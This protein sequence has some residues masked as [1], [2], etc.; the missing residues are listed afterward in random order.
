MGIRTGKVSSSRARRISKGGS[1]YLP[2]TLPTRDR[3]SDAP[4][5]KKIIS[6]SRIIHI[7]YVNIPVPRH[8]IS[9]ILYM[10]QYLRN[11]TLPT[12]ACDPAMSS[13]WVHHDLLHSVSYSL[14]H[15]WG[16]AITCNQECHHWILAIQ[17]SQYHWYS[18]MFI[19]IRDPLIPC[20]CGAMGKHLSHGA[21]S[22]GFGEAQTK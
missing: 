7:V 15:G 16:V 5:S 18:N 4:R 10:L 8:T 20:A 2:D 21:H 9:F 13:L 19:I 17:S 3:Y 12:N 6:P 14:K 1:G 11:L 22:E